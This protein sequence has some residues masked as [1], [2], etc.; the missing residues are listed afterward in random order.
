VA[1]DLS[2]GQQALGHRVLI[3]SLETPP[4]GRLAGVAR[5]RGIEVFTV[6]KRDGFDATVILRARRLLLNER[7]SLVHTHNQL[8]L[9][10]CA[11]A[12]KLARAR[13]VHTKHGANFERGR[14]LWLRRAAAR[15][16][17]AYV[18]VSAPTAELARRDREAKN[19]HVIENGIELSRFERDEG[20][21]RA[22]R[23][24]LS[25]PEDAFVFGMVGRVVPE[26]NHEL[27]LRALA[28]LLGDKLRLVV[29]GDGDLLASLSAQRAAGVHWLGARNDIA[30]LY[31]TFDALLLS[32][33]TEGLPLVVLEAMAAGLPVVAT[34]VG[35]VP[36]VVEHERTGLLVAPEDEAGLRE[37]AARL[38]SDRSLALGWGGAGRARAHERFSSERMVRDYIELYRNVLGY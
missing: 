8:P 4:S 14:R 24:E 6:P 21:R 15:M 20:M 33:R 27:A 3:V 30:R 11:P 26:K 17:D 23:R 1:I 2:A 25:I 18:A 35:G 16:C 28:P 12:G 9:I 29:A 32:S 37:A 31:S 10:Y 13:V 34:R 36:G 19:V 38:V 22:M 7:V 5:E